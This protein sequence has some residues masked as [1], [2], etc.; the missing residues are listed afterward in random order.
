MHVASSIPC[1]ICRKDVVSPR[2]AVVFPDFIPWAGH[3][4]HRYSG[5]TIHDDCLLGWDHAEHFLG[6]LGAYIESQSVMLRQPRDV[7]C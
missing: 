7:A 1:A 3:P 5:S 2:E 4:L 6:E